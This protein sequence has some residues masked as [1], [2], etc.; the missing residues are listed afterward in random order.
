MHASLP[1][2][3]LPELRAATDAWWRGLAGHL[4]AAG[5]P[6]VP[7]RLQRDPGAAA[8]GPD[9]LL[10]QVCGYPLTHAL[11]GRV[12]RVCTPCYAAPG[13][14]GARYS[15]ALVV[16][17]SSGAATLA[18]LRG[19]VCAINARNSHSGCNVLRRMLAPL[20]GGRP[21][22]ARVT[23][24]GSHEASLAAV[25]A[26]EADLC[27]VDAVTHA[28]LERHAPRRLAGTRVLEFSPSA[29]GLPYVTGGD[30]DAAELWRMRAAIGAA[31]ADP[32]LEAVRADLLISGAEIPGPESYDEI[33]AMEREAIALGYPELR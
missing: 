16:P 31:L 2:Y 21:Y 20:A 23:R 32:G 30:R 7:A 22:F 33:P 8:T 6:D 19:G 14:A 3:D 24:T 26:G 4:R 29:P 15:S 17:A 27:A 18:D 10:T 12:Q 13:C 1:M 9:L 5:F 28:L 25:A 11:A